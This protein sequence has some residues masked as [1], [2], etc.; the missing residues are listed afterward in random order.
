MFRNFNFQ[1]IYHI[2]MQHLL[3]MIFHIP[4]WNIEFIRELVSNLIDFIS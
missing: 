4:Q 2:I 3:D 1:I